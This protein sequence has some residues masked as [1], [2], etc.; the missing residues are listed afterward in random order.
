MK[1]NSAFANFDR[2][3]NWQQ[4]ES[5]ASGRAHFSCFLQKK[6]EKKH[7]H[8]HSQNQKT[9]RKKNTAMC[10]LLTVVR[11]GRIHFIRQPHIVLVHSQYTHTP[12]PPPHTL[13]LMWF[14]AFSSFLVWFYTLCTSFTIQCFSSSINSVVLYRSVRKQNVEICVRSRISHPTIIE[15]HIH[16][17]SLFPIKHTHNFRQIL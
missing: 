12:P 14:F 11:D 2:I 4:A 15:T 8:T 13:M 1:V 10:F 5:K 16:I 3:V 7:T 17:A 6:T 9:P